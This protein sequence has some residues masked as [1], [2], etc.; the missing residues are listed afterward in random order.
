MYVTLKNVGVCNEVTPVHTWN[1]AKVKE[2]F[3]EKSIE[4][5]SVNMGRQRNQL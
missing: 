1:V 3:E 5:G 2:V 4:C